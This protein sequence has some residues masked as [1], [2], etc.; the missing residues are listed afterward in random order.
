MRSVVVFPAPLGPSRPKISPCRTEKDRSRTAVLLFALVFSSF[1][2][3]AER[4]KVF[5]RPLACRISGI[6]HSF[7][8]NGS[9]DHCTIPPL[10]I[11][12]FL[13]NLRDNLRS[14]NQPANPR[15][16]LRSRT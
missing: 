5:C 14:S 12:L 10:P 3:L 16:V 9:P 4:R 2:C 7:F 11:P 1:C 13:Q 8:L 15:R 6:V